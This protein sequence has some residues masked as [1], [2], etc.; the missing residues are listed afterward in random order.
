MNK[1]RTS[2]AIDAARPLSARRRRVKRGVVASYIHEISG[3][4]ADARS[5]S[6]DEEN[7]L[8]AGPRPVPVS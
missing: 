3:R 1:H 7:P 4:H 6:A 8:A 5:A 2:A